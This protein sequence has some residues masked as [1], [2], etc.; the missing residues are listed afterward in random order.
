ML[1]DNKLSKKQAL[2]SSQSQ[3]YSNMFMNQTVQPDTPLITE[4]KIWTKQPVS[5]IHNAEALPGSSIPGL[6]RIVK[7]DI[8]IE[9]KV[10]S[11]FTHFKLSQSAVK[12]H[13]FSLT[14]AHDSLGNPENHHLEE[15]QNFLGKR[16]T[17]VFKYKDIDEGPER[18]FVGVI[19]E[20][21]FS[22]K[23]GNLGNIVLTGYSPGILLDAAPHTQSFGGSQ[24]ISLNSI[25]DK[26]IT[27]RSGRCGHEI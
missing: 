25:A 27:E 6:N 24:Q 2:K 12:H 1:Q 3:E 26:V 20:A 23:G 10:I 13:E 8:I 21:G 7:L 4:D 11:H 16:I 17:V 18:N 9:G 19:T 14:L 15:S 5:K 22:R